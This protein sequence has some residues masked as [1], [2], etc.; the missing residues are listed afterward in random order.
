MDILVSIS[1]DKEDHVRA[2][3]LNPISGLTHGYWTMPG[4]PKF[5]KAGDRIWFSIFGEVIASARVLNPRDEF[6]EDEDSKSKRAV[7]FAIST[8]VGHEFSTPR[9]LPVGF[10][11]FR[12][13]RRISKH[14][15]FKKTQALEV[16]GATK[17]ATL[18]PRTW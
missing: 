3:K 9:Q 12:Y 18:Y 10:R 17:T 8:V 14:T 1:P 11:G 16:V 13:V 6:N 15:P 2:T 5:L 7:C 4:H